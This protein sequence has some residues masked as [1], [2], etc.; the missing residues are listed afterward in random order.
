M[1]GL[2]FV[3]LVNHEQCLIIKTGV[4]WEPGNSGAES[5][6]MVIRR[7]QIFRSFV[8]VLSSFTLL[9]G[10]CTSMY[11]YSPERAA[12]DDRILKVGRDV[13]LT[14]KSGG[15]VRGKVTAFDETTISVVDETGT[16]SERI[17]FADIELLEVRRVSPGKTAG[18]SIVILLA[19]MV[20]ALSSVDCFA[21]C[22]DS[23]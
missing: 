22:F 23:N 14:L 19:V 13:E 1:P 18:L 12:A 21:F 20:A 10:G 11:A 8:V 15:F 17:K 4:R 7:N 5:M 16:I 9:L 6:L 3:R 2:F